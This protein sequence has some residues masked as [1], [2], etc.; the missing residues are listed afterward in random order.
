MKFFFPDSQ[1]QVDP[2]FDFTTEQSAEFRVRQ[3]DDRYAHELL[4]RPAYD[5]LLVSKPIVDG[6]PGAAGKYTLA[7]RH[8]L[9]RLG[10]RGFFRLDQ[11]SWSIQTMGDCGA[12]TYVREDRPPYSVDEVMDFYEGCGF[13]FGVAVDHVILGYD[14]SEGDPH[15]ET[16]RQ[17]QALTLDL[18]SDFLQAYRHRRP[19]FHPLGVAQ[20]WSPESYA[21]AVTALQ[22]MGYTYIALGGMVPLKTP[23]IHDCLRAAADVRSSN[24]TF[25]LLGVTRVDHLAAFAAFGVV[26]VDSTSPF[27]QAFKD[28]AD[29]YYS[30]D[31]NYVA[32]R[33][34]QSD[35]NPIVKGLIRAGRLD[36][37][38]ARD[39]ERLCLRRLEEFDRRECSARAL[40][41][42][43]RSYSKLFSPQR[44]RTPQYAELLDRCPWRHCQCGI[45]KVVGIQVA[46]FRGTERNKRRGFHNL[47]VFSQRL[48]AAAAPSPAQ[49]LQLCPV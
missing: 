25:H 48:A 31:R 24:V 42:A 26:S 3:R 23:Q 27:R 14:P 34:P 16:W 39:A 33:V 15:V 21:Y 1:D 11:P 30:V 35:A 32:I 6:L 22:D 43:L 2:Y 44:D 49:Q 29:N 8:R 10:A 17:R 18:A 12:F 45:C 28:D 5:G 7:Q 38:A 19:Q 36:Q 41:L 20:G 47:Y 9:Y 13:D 4:P 46:V 37:G 40:L